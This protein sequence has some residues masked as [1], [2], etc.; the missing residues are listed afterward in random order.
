MTEESPSGEGEQLDLVGLSLPQG[1]LSI[2]SLGE[3]ELALLTKPGDF[4]AVAACG[5]PRDPKEQSES[6]GGNQSREIIA[7]PPGL[8]QI[9]LFF[10]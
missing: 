7:S 3:S 2:S 6:G 10:F 1:S 4:P 8:N 5:I 9:R